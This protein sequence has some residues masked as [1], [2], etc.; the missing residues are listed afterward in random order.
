MRKVIM[1]LV[2]C[3]VP[4]LLLGLPPVTVK[5][6]PGKGGLC[7]TL[8]NQKITEVIDGVLKNAQQK[9]AEAS[10]KALKTGKQTVK[11]TPQQRPSY[12][13]RQ[14][15][16]ILPPIP[17]TPKQAYGVY[18]REAIEKVAA[19]FHKNPIAFPT[20]R[21]VAKYFLYRTI[22]DED[23]AKSS[24]LFTLKHIE[25]DPNPTWYIESHTNFQMLSEETGKVY[26]VQEGDVMEFDI[27]NLALRP[28]AEEEALEVQRLRIHPNAQ[29]LKERTHDT[30]L[31]IFTH[32][33][34]QNPEEIEWDLDDIAMQVMYSDG[35]RNFF[36]PSELYR[37][38]NL[39]NAFIEKDST[40][41]SD[42]ILFRPQQR[43]R[44][45]VKLSDG[46]YD[47]REV[48]PKDQLK[49][50][51]DEV[52]IVYPEIILPPEIN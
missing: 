2:V 39:Y 29:Q 25:N 12:H 23:F 10:Q 22:Q 35:E 9:A 1:L 7:T 18:Q 51:K 33:Y 17:Q 36:Y 52:V 27:Q 14:V 30:F 24:P 3:V 5:G 47:F 46:K 4:S 41:S 37:L 13:F 26:L 15:K 42:E 48:T 28:L 32:D 44:T 38:T 50:T 8:H 11:A 31:N 40:G 34:A 45:I 21:D 49:I 43:F 6:K 20:D 19:N 16:T